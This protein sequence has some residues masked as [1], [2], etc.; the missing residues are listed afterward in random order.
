MGKNISFSANSNYISRRTARVKTYGEV[1]AE[2]RFH[3]E[4][5][6]ADEDGNP[7]TKQTIGL[8]QRRHAGIDQIK[9]IGKESNSLEEVDAGL[10]HFAENIYTTYSDRRRDEWETK[11]RPA[12]KRI[13]AA[14]L[15]RE[16]GLSIRAIKYARTSG[17]RPHR[18]NQESL[19]AAILKLTGL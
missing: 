4:A 17:R 2:Y 12:L 16:T 11:I 10:I 19:A 5:K 7:A 3:P 9:Y 1:I 6:C 15:A 8:L 14:I 18:R 13:S